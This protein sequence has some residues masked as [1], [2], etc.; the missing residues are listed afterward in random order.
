[1]KKFVMPVPVGQMLPVM[2]VIII[3]VIH[4]WQLWGSLKALQY[5]FANGFTTAA[6]PDMIEPLTWEAQRVAKNK[7]EGRK[8]RTEI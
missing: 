5:V 7:M 1:M 8:K 2:E 3:I 6:F 4:S